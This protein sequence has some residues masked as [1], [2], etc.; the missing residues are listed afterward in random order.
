MALAAKKSTCRPGITSPNTH[1]ESTPLQ[2]SAAVPHQK[3]L[4][5][6]QPMGLCPK[7]RDF[8]R[9]SSGVRSVKEKA[10]DGFGGQRL[11]A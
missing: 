11:G 10:P 9:H 3:R 5:F 7:P 6:R 1:Y 8:L 2:E 4:S